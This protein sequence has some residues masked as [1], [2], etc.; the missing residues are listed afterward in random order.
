MPTMRQPGFGRLWAAQTVSDVGSELTMLALP[1][2]AILLLHATPLQVGLLSA[3]ELLP[4]V[5]FG[6]P[7]GVLVDRTPPVRVMV[8][9]DLGRAA[10]LATVP[11]AYL[12]GGLGV[13][14]LYLVAFAAG[15][16]TVAFGVAQQSAVHGLVDRRRLIDANSRIEL[17]GAVAA[18]S[19][20]GLG[21]ILIGI[22]SAPL[23]IALDALSF[24]VSALLLAG[25]R[26]AP[27]PAAGGRREGVMGQIREGL[28][29]IAAHPV[30]RALA[31]SLAVVNLFGGLFGAVYLIYLARHLHLGATVIGLVLAVAGSGAVAGAAVAARLGRRVGVGRLIALTASPFGFLL[32]PL[33]PPAFPL[34][35]LL[36]GELLVSFSGVVFNT[37]Q[38]G[39]RQALTPARLQGRM[40]ATI[41]FL[42]VAPGPVG[43]VA[44]GVLGSTVGIRAALWT[45]V[46]GMLLGAV[47]IL[48]SPIPGIRTIPDLDP[49]AAA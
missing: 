17:S 34:P 41:R 7:A 45:G 9:A 8:V 3:A 31:L 48:L 25:I 18:V 1:L 16:L 19:G 4:F 21:G 38:R 47:P 11:V 39:L 29:L 23:T 12:A 36:A 22:L 28:V 32:I 15:S 24:V 6:L 37:T 14:Q 40:T 5:V 49:D 26:S 44:G 46:V 10:L 27:P 20:P 42:I 13:V 30:L 2:T 43:A 35:W 33:A